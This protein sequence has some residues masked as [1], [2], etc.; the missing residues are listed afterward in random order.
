ML[1]NYHGLKLWNLA[2]LL[3]ACLYHQ[4]QP[5]ADLEGMRWRSQTLLLDHAAGVAA[6]DFKPLNQVKILL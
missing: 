1:H 4:F 2:V 3:L 6:G 5:E